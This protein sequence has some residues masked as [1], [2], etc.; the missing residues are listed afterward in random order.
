MLLNI[1]P[2]ILTFND[3]VV[4]EVLRGTSGRQEGRRSVRVVGVEGNSMRKKAFLVLLEETNFLPFLKA[5]ISVEF[6]MR[7][8]TS[9]T[10][11]ETLGM[12]I[13]DRVKYI[14]DQSGRCNGELIDGSINERAAGKNKKG[15]KPMLSSESR[16]PRLIL[17]RHRISGGLSDDL[18]R[19]S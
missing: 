1:I 4:G 10:T 19:R 9:A 14:D 3:E 6:G 5:F 12:L 18:S 15:K 11:N 7:I 2:I 17:S 8:C 13:V 16:A